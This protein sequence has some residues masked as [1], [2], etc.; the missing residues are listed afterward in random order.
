MT[1]S[2]PFYPAVKSSWGVLFDWDGVIIDSS[3]QHERSWEL[4]AAEEG[5]ILPEGHFKAGF[6]KKNEVIIPSLGWTQ[7]SSEVRRLADRKEELYREL[8][9]TEGVL[10][11]PGARELLL[12]LKEGG[13]PRAVGSSTPRGNLDALFAVTGLDTLFDAVVCGSDVLHG[14]PDPEVFLK[15]AEHL[16]L[17]P[18]R[19]VVVEDAFA[20]IEA[21]RRGG[22]KVIGVATTNPL[23]SLLDCDLAVTTLAEVTPARLAGLFQAP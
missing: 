18:E 5:L 19:C 6:G 20:G 1:R 3:S 13:I 11:L 2:I 22:M 17:N 16:D 10:V 7:D 23:E 21:A 9:A 4:L 14:K 12:A 15:G 8:V